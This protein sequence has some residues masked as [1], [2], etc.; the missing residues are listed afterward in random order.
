MLLLENIIYLSKQF[1]V[2]SCSISGGNLLFFVVLD[3]RNI[4]EGSK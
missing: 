2:H 4:Y 3:N 1:M